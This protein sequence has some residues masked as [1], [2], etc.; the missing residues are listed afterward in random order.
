ML[1]C[2][3]RRVQDGPELQYLPEPGSCLTMA[4]RPTDIAC[5]PRIAGGWTLGGATCTCLL[6][7]TRVARREGKVGVALYPIGLGPRPLSV[8]PTETRI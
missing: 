2:V 8:S 5:K 3:R 7:G 1:K 4:Y 6:V